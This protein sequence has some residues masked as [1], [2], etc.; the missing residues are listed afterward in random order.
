[1]GKCNYSVIVYE[2]YSGD[3]VA[4]DN[5]DR[6][7]ESNRTSIWSVR[8]EDRFQF[9]VIFFTLFL[10]GVGVVSYYEIW[11]KDS[12]SLIETTIAL[13]RD[14]GAVGLA[15]VVLALVRFEGWD[16][17]MGIA[18][19][20][21]QRQQYNKGVAAREAIWGDWLKSNPEVQKLIDEGKAKAPP[22]LNDKE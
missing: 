9:S 12:D 20:L 18:R 4:E 15:S 13:I 10:L 1:M 14:I 7:D 21:L 22:K 2:Q 17:I 6:D 8:T 16:S 5:H 3:E 11:L 19:E